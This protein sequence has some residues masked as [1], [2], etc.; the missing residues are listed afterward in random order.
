MLRS[1][2]CDFCDAYIVFEGD[3]TVTEK[4]F[5]ANDID[6]P[7]NTAANVTVTNT[8]NNNVFGDKK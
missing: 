1:N 7:N 5:T 8:A 2:L 4:T 3:I 6:A